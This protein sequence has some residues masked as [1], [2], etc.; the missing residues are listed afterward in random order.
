MRNF[1]NQKEFIVKI[2]DSGKPEEV[3]KLK[4][5]FQDQELDPELKRFIRKTLCW[6]FYPESGDKEFIR[7]VLANEINKSDDKI[8]QNFD[9]LV[10]KFRNR[11]NFVFS[12]AKRPTGSVHEFVSSNWL[13]SSG[14]SR[15][16]PTLD[17]YDGSFQ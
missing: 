4:E 8:F 1:L 3:A 16:K 14:R 15:P 10:T 17:N 6:Y 2:I 7:W 13:F 5:A 12:K 9:Y 11:E